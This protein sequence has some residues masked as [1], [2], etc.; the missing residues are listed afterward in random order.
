MG[1]EFKEH[2]GIRP[3]S[4]HEKSRPSGGLQARMRAL[5]AAGSARE[6]DLRTAR[7]DCE[8]ALVDGRDVHCTCAAFLS[9]HG[10]AAARCIGLR[11]G[12]SVLPRPVE[13]EDG[14]KA[15]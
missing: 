4:K 11:C 13:E 8:H 10:A 6:A 3:R 14:K 7:P 5:G 2:A 1:E 12:F 9:K 15:R